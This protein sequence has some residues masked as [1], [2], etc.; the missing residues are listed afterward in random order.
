MEGLVE[1]IINVLSN[2]TIKKAQIERKPETN[3][4]GDQAKYG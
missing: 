3:G 4:E 1:E 2:P